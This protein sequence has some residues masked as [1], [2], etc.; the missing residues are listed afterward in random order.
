MIFE[1]RDLT[2]VAVFQPR[3]TPHWIDERRIAVP[4][5][6]PDKV[7]AITK[8]GCKLCPPLLCSLAVSPPIYS[9]PPDPLWPP[10][11]P[12]PKGKY[13]DGEAKHEVQFVLS[14]SGAP[15]DAITC[16]PLHAS[17]RLVVGRLQL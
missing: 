10:T 4:N 9:P 8:L 11:P 13:P 2:F 5:L 17:G 14:E 7:R 15:N 6:Q 16:A 12:G 1:L 3:L